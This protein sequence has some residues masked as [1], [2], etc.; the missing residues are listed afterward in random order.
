[1]LKSCS[2]AAEQWGCKVASLL[3]GRPQPSWPKPTSGLRASF[4]TRW[5][6]HFLLISTLFQLL[7]LQP[8]CAAV[9][10]IFGAW[11]TGPGMLGWWGLGGSAWIRSGPDQGQSRGLL[12]DPFCSLW[13]TVRGWGQFVKLVMSLWRMVPRVASWNH[14]IWPLPP[15][16]SHH[17]DLVVCYLSCPGNI[18]LGCRESFLSSDGLLW[19]WLWH[20]WCDAWK[21]AELTKLGLVIKSWLLVLL[22]GNSL[23]S[24]PFWSTQF[25]NVSV[26]W[27]VGDA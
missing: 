20:S 12:V 3:E 4:V 16:K 7:Q 22:M 27:D 17:L 19:D 5:F 8:L 13:G 26:L 24:E 11:D 2:T 25:K 23:S 10:L 1:M 18:F 14:I 15:L 6:S 9:Y 21:F